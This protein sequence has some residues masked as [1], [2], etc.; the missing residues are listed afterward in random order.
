MDRKFK[1]VYV[2]HEEDISRAAW[3]AE[4]VS[5]SSSGNKMPQYKHAAFHAAVV[6]ADKMYII[7]LHK[8]KKHDRDRRHQP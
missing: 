2:R 4:S 8:T 5:K 3:K 7:Q 6:G 1:M